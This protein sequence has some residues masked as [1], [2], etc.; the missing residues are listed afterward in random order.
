MLSE[1]P[2]PY[3]DTLV[4]VK[5]DFA[6]RPPTTPCSRASPT[7]TSP[8]PTTRSRCPATAD[9]NNGNTNTTT[10]YDFVASHTWTLGGHQLNQFAFHFQDF[11]NEILPNVTDVPSP[12]FPSVDTGPNANTPQQTT[13]EEV[14]V[15]QRL[16][17]AAGTARAE[18][19]R[20]T[21]S[22]R[23]WAATSTSARPATRSP[24]FDDP[25]A[26]A[27]NRTLYP[28]GFAT[29]GAVRNIQYAAGQASHEQDFHQ[30][31]FYAAG[32]LARSTPS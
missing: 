6:S 29:P 30:I 10:N 20:A 7:R 2:T 19:R 5:I 16:H 23:S 22:T 1:I 9:L 27:N 4:T 18:V 24:F 26:I 31:A 28:Q 11:K 12:D 14:P 8:R 15:P 13:R 17:L 25:L 3:D 21:T 32:R